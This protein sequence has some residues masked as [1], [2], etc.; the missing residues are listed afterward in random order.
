MISINKY[1]IEPSPSFENELQKIYS[2]IR[3]NLSEP[4]TAV[5]FYKIVKKS[6]YSLQFFPNR[7]IKIYNSK[8]K[9][10][11]RLLINN[12]LIIYEVNDIIR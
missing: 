5:K 2:Y 6:I 12:Y 8:N 10:I 3:Y 1:L 7:N 11:R 9:N 4:K